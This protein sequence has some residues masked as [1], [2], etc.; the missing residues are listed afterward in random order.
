MKRAY[1][2]TVIDGEF[3]LRMGAVLRPEARF[4]RHV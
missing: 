1:F 4:G 2:M 3:Y